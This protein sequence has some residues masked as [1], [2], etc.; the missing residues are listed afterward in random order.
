MVGSGLLSGVMTLWGMSLRAK[1]EQQGI[2]IPP[3]VLNLLAQRA[4][5]NIRELE[6][7]LNRVIAYAR[8][9]RAEVS[10]PLAA[11]AIEDITS[12]SPQHPDIATNVVIEAVARSFHLNPADLKSRRRDR[13]TALARQVAMYLIRQ[14]ANC[15]LAQIGN[16]LGGRDHSTVIHACG[17]IAR[18]IDNSPHLRRKITD[19]QHT[20]SSGKKP[21]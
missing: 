10:P 8:L 7:L 2:A 4:E 21:G 3:D 14:E 11:R 19:I 15:S 20:L 6:G 1:A 17:K 13:E 12:L 9:M 16:E 18:E 5:H